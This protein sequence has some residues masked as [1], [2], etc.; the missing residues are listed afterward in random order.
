METQLLSPSRRARR[1]ESL[2]TTLSSSPPTLCFQSGRPP[3][4]PERAM[5]AHVPPGRAC[6]QGLHP[7]QN[8]TSL[9]PPGTGGARSAQAHLNNPKL[10]F[11]CSRFRSDNKHFNKDTPSSHLPRPPHESNA[12]RSFQSD[13]DCLDSSAHVVEINLS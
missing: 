3:P 1:R 9:R 7:I 2:F 13:P 8:Q 6:G 12:A 4:G 11:T 5:P 10:F